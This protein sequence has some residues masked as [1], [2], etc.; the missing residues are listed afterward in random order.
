VGGNLNWTPVTVVRTSLAEVDGTGMKRQLD[1]YGLWKF[2]PNA[3]LRISGNNLFARKYET[4]RTIDT[5]G[6]VQ[7]IDTLA[8]TY[9][10]LGV[11]VELKI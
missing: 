9:T 1:L 3:Q 10:T 7:S 5:Y 2:G 11:R 4:A 6:L 8:R